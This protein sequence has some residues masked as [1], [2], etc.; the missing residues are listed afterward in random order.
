M[1]LWSR[2][3]QKVVQISFVLISKILNL[4]KLRWIHYGNQTFTEVLY[5]SV[6]KLLSHV[7]S[8]LKWR[9]MDRKP[10]ER[11]VHQDGRVVLLGDACHPM[12]V[13]LLKWLIS[14]NL[15]IKLFFHF[16]FISALPI[17]RCR[18]GNRGWFYVGLDFVQDFGYF[19]ELLSF[20]ILW[21]AEIWSHLEDTSCKST[22]STCLSPHEWSGTASP[23]W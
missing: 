21:E 7:K 11:W 13:R 15:L 12:L 19:T 18:N 2:G 5:S 22:K 17:T 23:W 4:G 16:P 1:V 14:N 8:T 3:R 6:K 10:L 9:L 20:A